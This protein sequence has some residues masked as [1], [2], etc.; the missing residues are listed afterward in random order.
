MPYSASQAS[1]SGGASGRGCR[2]WLGRRRWPQWSPLGPG[3]RIALP[4]LRWLGFGQ[5]QAGWL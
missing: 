1:K 5:N 2:R 4:R 3:G